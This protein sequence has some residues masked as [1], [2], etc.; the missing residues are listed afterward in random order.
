MKLVYGLGVYEK[1]YYQ[2]SVGKKLTKVYTLW[3]SM[4]SRCV[5]DGI[6]PTNL[7]TYVGC[8]VHPD[9]IKFQDFAGW[10]HAQVGFGMNGFQL[11]KDILVSGNK[12]YG[13]DTCVFVPSRINTYFRAIPPTGRLRGTQRRPG[14]TKRPWFAVAT[15]NGVR[16]SLGSFSTEEEAHQAYVIAYNSEC[17]RLAESWK[18]SIDPR[19]YAAMIGYRL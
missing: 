9:F 10:C 14:D 2:C 18:D 5:N 1:G 12:V 15:V 4:L 11:D 16:K 7:P 6:Q 17:V 13:P 3:L 8:E 19:V